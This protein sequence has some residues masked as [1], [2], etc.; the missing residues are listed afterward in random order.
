VERSYSLLNTN[1]PNAEIES[2]KKTHQILSAYSYYNSE[3]NYRRC[4]AINPELYYFVELIDGVFNYTF[5]NF[6]EN[7]VETIN[8][9]NRKIRYQLIKK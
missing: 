6:K 7:Y 9:S 3:N 4:I 5:I 8:E 1:T 2:E